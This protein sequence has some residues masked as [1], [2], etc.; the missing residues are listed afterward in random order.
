MISTDASVF[1]IFPEEFIYPTDTDA[2]RQRIQTALQKKQSITM[3]AGGTSLGGQAIGS[4]LLVDISKHLTRILDYRPELK[5]IDVEPGVIQDDLNAFVKQDN[6][7]FAPDTSTSNRAM[8]GGMI[9]NNSCGSYSVY[10]GTTR[11]HV[12]A[13]EMILADGSQ[14]RFDD[15][16][17]EQ[18]HDKLNLQS[19]EGEI[20]RT[21]IDLLEK[22][23]PEIVEHFPDPS[24]VRRTT[25]YA[26]DVLYTD[27]Q[28][29]IRTAN[30]ST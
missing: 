14:V 18:L 8:I 28:P 12:K 17:A 5:E 15:L 26:L 19:L 1:E 2:L 20:Y 10:Y 23:G 27:Y 9:G 3:R 7:R 30:R 11:D 6:L 24:I 13:V 4:G 25:G 29:S 22:H 21:V 16:S